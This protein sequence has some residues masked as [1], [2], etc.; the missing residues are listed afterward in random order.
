[1]VSLFIGDD[2]EE[3]VRDEEGEKKEADFNPDER[4]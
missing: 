3:V 4:G 2:L 1:M